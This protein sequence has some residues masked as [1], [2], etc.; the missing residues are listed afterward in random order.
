[1]NVCQFKIGNSCSEQHTVPPRPHGCAGKVKQ[2][3]YSL[4]SP[5]PKTTTCSCMHCFL[6]LHSRNR[7]CF[8]VEQV[9]RPWKIWSVHYSIPQTNAE[10][11]TVTAGLINNN[12]ALHLLT[13]YNS[14]NIRGKKIFNIQ[15]IMSAQNEIC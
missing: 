11:P 6:G 8:Y 5:V 12:L 14:L 2:R 4:Q 7:S 15:Q 1:M 9:Y 3:K 10:K 13:Y